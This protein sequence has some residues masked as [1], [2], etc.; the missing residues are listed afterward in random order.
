MVLA[1]PLLY[2][3]EPFRRIRLGALSSYHV[4]HLALETDLFCRR[5]RLEGVPP[6]TRYIMVSGPPAN[7]ALLDLFSREGREMRII[8]SLTLR[9]VYALVA[10]M[11]RRTRF[12]APLLRDTRYY[13]LLLDAQLCHVYASSEPTLSFSPSEEAYGREELARMGIGP[14]DWFVAFHS[15]DSAYFASRKYSDAAKHDHRDTAT[16]NFLSAA[17]A[18]V[19]LGGYAVRMGAVV[20]EP[21]PPSRDKRI[22][23][24]AVDFRSDFMDVYLAARCRF[25]LGTTSGLVCLP[26]LFDT[27][28]A[29][30]N[31]IPYTALPWNRKG[32]FIPKMLRRREGGAILTFEECEQLGLFDLATTKPVV[33]SRYYAELGLEVLENDAQ[34]VRALAIDMHDASLGRVPCAEARD[35]QHFYKSRFLG[36]YPGIAHAGDLAPSFALRYRHLITG[37][38]PGAT[39]AP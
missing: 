20:T 36:G 8:E 2:A 39:K 12:A 27:P 5:L 1:L 24:Y 23:D 31:V 38:D 35:L 34:D 28:V 11:L 30:S 4:G 16:E 37:S 26:H 14:D 3:I 15:R 33:Q 25:F 9:R 29:M 32:L 21:L 7:R 22:I 18:M 10:P 19:D 17:Q 13:P 6:R